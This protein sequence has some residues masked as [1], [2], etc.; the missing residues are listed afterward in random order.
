MIRV[1]DKFLLFLY[2][3]A[4]G[5]VAVIAFCAGMYW[6]PE[7]WLSNL[8]HNLYSG[9][10]DWLQ[11][12]VLIVSVIVFL[13][14]LRFFYVSLKRSNASSPSI[15]QRTEFGD[16]R[17]SLETVENLALKA[18]SRQRGVKELKARIR[19]SEAGIEVSLR[20]IADGESSIPVLTEEIQRA[21]KSHV[22]EITGI[23]VAGVSV[24]VANIIQTANFKS[25]VE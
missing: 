19:I 12:T 9:D 18:A 6:F 16:I 21:V 22:E 4:I 3:L 17:I 14:S 13:I 8:V 20:A 5:A 10:Y 15:D 7:D 25:R 23:P 1:L 11:A 24:F 2:S